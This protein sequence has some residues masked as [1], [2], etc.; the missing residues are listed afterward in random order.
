M[1]ATILDCVSDGSDLYEC[2][3]IPDRGVIYTVFRDGHFTVLTRDEY[4]STVQKIN[5]DTAVDVPQECQ[6]IPY[7]RCEWCAEQCCTRFD[8]N[9][10]TVEP[11][12]WN[13]SPDRYTLV[14]RD[15]L[16]VQLADREWA[17]VQKIKVDGITVTFRF[18]TKTEYEAFQADRRKFQKENS[19][20]WDADLIE[21]MI[22]RENIISCC[23]EQDQPHTYEQLIFNT[24]EAFE[25]FAEEHLVPL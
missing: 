25:S 23:I 1:V 15:S 8:L 9:E 19:R 4:F 24:Q 18:Q 12:V 20:I 21:I 10:A 14:E 6:C 13:A 17:C 16:V 22:N 2:L 3:A 11:W 7:E 5:G